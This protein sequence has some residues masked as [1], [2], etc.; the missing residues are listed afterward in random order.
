MK[1]YKQM[2]YIFDENFIFP[3]IDKFQENEKKKI[4]IHILEKALQEH[5][6]VKIFIFPIIFKMYNFSC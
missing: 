2:Q 3:I 1:L 6:N 4:S 5:K